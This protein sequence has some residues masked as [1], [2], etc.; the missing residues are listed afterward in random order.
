[1][2]LGH[3]GTTH[4][5]PSENLV[6]EDGEENLWDTH[7][8]SGVHALGASSPR[9]GS[10]VRGFDWDYMH[11]SICDLLHEKPFFYHGTPEKCDA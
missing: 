2:V 9:F 7:A 8:L 3:Q 5:Q 4:E 11:R 6:D 1:M 10:G